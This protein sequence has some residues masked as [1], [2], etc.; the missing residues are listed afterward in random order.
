VGST[1]G[2]LGLAVVITLV[3]DTAVGAAP[4]RRAGA[5]AAT[6]ETSS[7]LG[8]ALGLAILG[9]IGAAIYRGAAPDGAGETIGEA[10]ATG[11]AL[12]E[13]ARDAFSSALT[14]TAALSALALVLTAV[15]GMALLRRSP[16]LES[17][18]A[19]AA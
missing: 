6:A 18:A 5:A 10:A 3:T 11:G 17:P 19:A 1:I 13:A 2:A 15:C 4:R 9:S 7:E 8:G 14:A 16:D 12:L